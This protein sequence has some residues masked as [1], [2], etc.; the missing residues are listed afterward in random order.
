MESRNRAVEGVETEG[1]DL[2]QVWMQPQG[3][4]ELVVDPGRTRTTGSGELAAG[5]LLKYVSSTKI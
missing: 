3:L 5:L 4:P 1:T 2:R